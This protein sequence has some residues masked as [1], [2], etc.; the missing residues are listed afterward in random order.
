MVNVIKSNGHIFDEQYQHLRDVSNTFSFN[1][2]KDF[3]DHYLRKDVLLY[4]DL[5]KKFIFTCLKYYYLDP[6]PYFS[7]PGLSRDVMLKMIKVELE[8]I[9]DRDKYM[10]FEQGRR[11]GVSYINKRYSEASNN[12]SVLYL[13]MNNLYRCAM[14]QYLPI[15]DFKCNKNINKIEQ[16]LMNIKNNSSTGYVLEA[17]LE[18]LQELR[19]INNDYPLALEKINIPK[20]LLSDYC[21][22]IANIHIVTTGTVKKLVPNL[23]DKNNY[24]S[25]QQCQELGMKLNKIHRILKFKQSDWMKPHID[26]NT[27]KRKEATNDADKNYCKLLNNAVYGKLWK[28]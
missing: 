28:I 16:K 5:F 8:K 10:F 17:D 26:F 2:F 9:S 22:K 14:S 18:H 21:L 13:D 7:A 25:L 27:Q 6:C 20:E 24:R 3:D 19:D 11:G 4:A 12:V 23:L 1:A 15:S